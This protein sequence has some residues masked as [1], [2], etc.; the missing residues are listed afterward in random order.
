MTS[1]HFLFFSYPAG[2]VYVYLILYYVTEF[3]KNIRLAQYLFVGIYLI[4]ISAVFYIYHRT[5]KVTF[6]ETKERI[7]WCLCFHLGTT[8]RIHLHVLFSLSHSLDLCTPSLQWSDCNDIPLHIDY[9]SASSP[10]DN[11][12]YSLQVCSMWWIVPNVIQMSFSLA[13]S[14]KMN[15]LLMAPALFFILLLSVGLRATI[16]HILYCALLQ[17]GRTAH[18][19]KL[20]VGYRSTSVVVGRS[21]SFDQSNRIYRTIV[22]SRSSIFL[23]LDGELALYSWRTVS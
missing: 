3:G 23:H 22:W 20:D 4:L 12:L 13:V 14:I 8:L 11:R 21:V 9:F 10:M 6:D 2:F 17:V 18:R 1:C 19:W 16:Q 7:H 5:A 15:I